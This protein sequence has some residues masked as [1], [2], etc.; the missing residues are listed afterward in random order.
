MSHEQKVEHLKSQYSDRYLAPFIKNGI[1]Y[2][3]RV[4]PDEFM[5]QK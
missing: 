3:Y 2:D 4:D 1:R 5:K